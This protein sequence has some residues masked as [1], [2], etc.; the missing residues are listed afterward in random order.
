M[1]CR[2]VIN[3]G[4]NVKNWLDNNSLQINFDKS[5]FLQ[6]KINSYHNPAFNT[7]TLHNN[8]CTLQNRHYFCSAIKRANSVKYLGLYHDNCLK[9]NINIDRLIKISIKFF[10]VF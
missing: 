4:L 2:C 1:F 3:I 9:R 8:I 7:L 6:F 5:S 10:Y